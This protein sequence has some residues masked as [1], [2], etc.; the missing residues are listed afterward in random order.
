VTLP[1]ADSSRVVLVGASRFIDP[2]LGG[3]PAVRDNLADLAACF[4]DPTLWGLP[5]E[6][7]VQVLDPSSADALIDPIHEAARQATDTLIVY[8]AGH[9][10][11]D[12]DTNE[13]LLAL[14]ATIPGR[15]HTAVPYEYVRRNLRQSPARRRVVI[16]DCCYSGKA[17]GTMSATSI[18]VADQAS[19]AGTYV[20]ASAPPNRQAL[21]PP[22]HRYTTF[23]GE[24][25]SVLAE[26]L[27]GAG[28]FL[29]LD[30]IYNHIHHTLRSNSFPEP[31]K[32]GGNTA[33]DLALVRNR[34]WQPST[35]PPASSPPQPG[36]AQISTEL[37]PKPEFAQKPREKQIRPIVKEGVIRLRAKRR[38]TRGAISLSILSIASLILTVGVKLLRQGS[39]T[40][41]SPPSTSISSSNS[42]APTS[43]TPA[44]LQQHKAG[45][46][47]VAFSPDGRVLASG[48]DD[49][50]IRGQ[51]RL[52]QLLGSHGYRMG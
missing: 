8:Y 34:L 51:S 20:L 19:I 49:K 17:L 29:T 6:H 41:D 52:R 22:G 11:L 24:L 10:L 32:R 37:S 27:T 40:T 46:K 42:V 44:V 45:V 50:A 31:Q 7:C 13:L 26:G 33:G 38:L 39:T 28:Q 1:S 43:G 16:V 21:S 2:G 14:V 12:H 48:G 23:T 47:T 5:A 3:L 4:R 15:T 9:G 25:I 36:L 30:A 35:A 18:A